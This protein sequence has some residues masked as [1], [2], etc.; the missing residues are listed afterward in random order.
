MPRI[1]LTDFVDIVSSGGTPKANKVSQIKNRLPY[2]P[3]FDFYKP[4]RD[5]IIEVH[6]I[7][8]TKEYLKSLMPLI[9]DRKKLTAYPAVIDGY[10]SWWGKKK[11]SWFNPPNDLFS[12]HGIDVSVNPELGLYINGDPYLIKLYF[13]AE[14]LTKNRVDVIHH[15]MGSVLAPVSPNGT[16]MAVLEIRQSKLYAPT[17]QIPNLTAVLGAEL[18]YISALWANV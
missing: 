12:F 11:F 6:N 8:E 4:L 16:T 15:L 2:N 10:L 14:R 9:S 1:S 3:A 7:G 18:A 17:I 5:R 13:K